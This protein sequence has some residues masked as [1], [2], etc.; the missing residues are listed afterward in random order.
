MACMAMVCSAET[1][2]Q[3]LDKIEKANAKVTSI[4]SNFEETKV[5]V[6]KKRIPMAG[7]LTYKAPDYMQKAYTQPEGDLFLIQNG[8]L[9]MRSQG[10]EKKYDLAKV[11]M[12]NSLANLLLKAMSG[13]IRSLAAENNTS[14]YTVMDDGK[15]YIVRFEAKEKAAVGYSNITFHYRKT[16]C[17]L[18]QLDM[19]EFSGMASIYLLKDIK[20]K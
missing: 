10:K 19:V 13:Q 6:N 4:E 11:P 5:L 2:D 18:V 14:D 8:M 9:T 17:L 7:V 12:M 15:D 3:M 1:A 20:T 16:D